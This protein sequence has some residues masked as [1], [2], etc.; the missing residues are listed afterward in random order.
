MTG[1]GANTTT[2]LLEGE[3]LVLEEMKMSRAKRRLLY[4]I[5][6][7]GLGLPMLFLPFSLG[8][9][10]AVGFGLTFLGLVYFIDAVLA[11]RQVRKALGRTSP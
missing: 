2:N 7:L 10:E 9:F 8:I 4:S 11:I 3:T 1:I 6:F 5:I